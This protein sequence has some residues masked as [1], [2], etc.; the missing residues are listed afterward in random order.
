[1]KVSVLSVRQWAAEVVSPARAQ[2]R[3]ALAAAGMRLMAEGLVIWRARI[4]MGR[5]PKQG[6][7]GSDEAATKHFTFLTFTCT[8][9]ICILP[10]DLMRK[11]GWLPSQTGSTSPAVFAM[12]EVKNWEQNRAKIAGCDWRR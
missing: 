11:C 9:Y 12:T 1:M 10:H 6:R 7:M 2:A 8:S 4:R 3:N 5:R